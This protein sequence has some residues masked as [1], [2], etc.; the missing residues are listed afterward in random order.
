MEK[1]S[2]RKQNLMIVLLI[3]ILVFGYSV[4][5]GRTEL[6]EN[7][8]MDLSYE[9]SNANQKLDNL[10]YSIKNEFTR[11]QEETFNLVNAFDYKYLDMN[12]ETETIS[13][14][15][16]TELKEKQKESDIVL[17]ISDDSGEV[18]EE[19]MKPMEGLLYSTTLDL[20][21]SKNYTVNLIEDSVND[22]RQL[23]MDTYIIDLQNQVEGQRIK[24]SENSV[25]SN[26]KAMFYNIQ[27][28]VNDFGIEAFEM[29]S[30]VFV[31]ESYAYD[32][33]K[34]DSQM[35]TPIYKIDVTDELYKYV[36]L[37]EEQKIKVAAG[38]LLA[39]IPKD[40]A[41]N[42]LGSMN[43]EET[44]E[45]E[46]NPMGED[47]DNNLIFDKNTNEETFIFQKVMIYDEYKDINLGEIKD[48]VNGYLIIEFKDGK[49]I[50]V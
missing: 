16:Q 36:E 39:D 10:G 19:K 42:F 7:R 44:V 6:L 33:E 22:S 49:K 27:F 28:S 13:V 21:L 17:V 25:E 34:T 30:A 38:D 2:Q 29:Q 46:K 23:N 41:D 37:S 3:V 45:S 5:K 11:M 31:I 15:V 24:V 20:S 47:N 14:Q 35:D 26:N 4:S 43:T 32:D 9:V 40:L 18:R 50:E 1:N 12:K 8:I 48:E